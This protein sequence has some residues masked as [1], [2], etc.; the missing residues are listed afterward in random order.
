VLAS[1]PVKAESVPIVR[2]NAGL[3]DAWYN[4]ATNGQGFF[5]N[6]FPVNGTAFVGWFTYDL[7]RP[8]E[9]ADAQLGEA[10]HRWLTA[11]G[12]FSGN[13]ANLT[14]Y[15]TQGGEFDSVEPPTSFDPA[16]IGTMVIEFADCNSALISYDI[17]SLGL[18]GEI[19]IQRIAQDNLELC[20]MLVA[21]E[22][23]PPACTRA[24]PDNSHG[25]NDPPVERGAIIDR[26][27]MADGGT[28]WDG[29][30][31]IEFP[32]FTED[33]NSGSFGPQDLVAGVKVGDEVRAYPHNILNWH[34]V[35]NDQFNI[36]GGLER[37]TLNYCPLTGSAMLWKSLMEP[38][39]ETWG[40]SG[41]LYNS[42][43]VMYDRQ[44]ESFWSQMLEQA[45]IGQQVK[46]IPDRLQVVETTWATWQAM[47]PETSVLTEDTGYTRDYGAYPYGSYREDESL[48]FE[49]NNMND[50]R[51]PRKER[52][53]GINVGDSSKVYPINNF[54]SNVE[55]I[56][57]MVGDMNVVAAGSSNQ[58]FGVVYNRELEDC[59]V[60]EFE[61]V[62]NELP[63]VMRDNEGNK[64]DVFGTA[65]SGARTGQQLQKTNSYIAYWF[66]W[67]AFF[68][69]VQIHQ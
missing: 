2:L 62:Q 11:Q 51:L 22:P 17:P 39:D 69:H 21:A 42:N 55:V 19:P 6:V 52:V 10:G 48:L 61:A 29:I 16:G 4:P 38:G 60:L 46:K 32:K 36:S 50:R 28:G 33:L 63:V 35:V 67:T 30:P 20:E 23:P 44:T 27:Q 26:F 68:P 1:T 53:L 18:T 41:V 8:D 37:A 34:E 5:I 56:N 65:V 25:P 47:Y 49:V 59:T 40:V 12:P 14:I 9:S 24:E 45:V 31:A 7:E 66:A 58:N 57:E 43:L 3:N 13:T 64:W 15:V 54:A